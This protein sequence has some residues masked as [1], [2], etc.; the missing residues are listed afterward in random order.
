M[1]I[2][3]SAKDG[4]LI[5]PCSTPLCDQMGYDSCA[6][7]LPVKLGKG[8]VKEVIIPALTPERKEELNKVADKISEMIAQAGY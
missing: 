8:G 6:M 5:I 2:E 7:G 3:S 1:M 4:D